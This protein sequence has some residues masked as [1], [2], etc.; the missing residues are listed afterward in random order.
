MESD[1]RSTSSSYSS[2]G[3][4]APGSGVGMLMVGAI[5]SVGDAVVSLLTHP[6]LHRQL[7]QDSDSGSD[8]EPLLIY[9]PPRGL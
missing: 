3:L 8:C 2:T 1:D 6:H 9:S 5:V 4:T 7:L